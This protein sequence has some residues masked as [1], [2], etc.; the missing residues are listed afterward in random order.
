LPWSEQTPLVIKGVMYLG[1]PY[2]R[3]VALDADSGKELW[4]YELPPGNQPA[5]RGL[6]YWPGTASQPAQIMVGT[7]LGGK[8]IA[9]N[10]E[11]GRPV[12]GFADHGILDLKTPDVMNGFPPA[13][14]ALAMGA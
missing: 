7:Q 3:V 9:L 1:V 14:T 8:L 11:T 13:G 5:T 12:E 2:G 4:V 10:A 6:A